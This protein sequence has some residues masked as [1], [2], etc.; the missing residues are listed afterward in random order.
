[1][2]AGD[3]YTMQFLFCDRRHVARFISG[4]TRGGKDSDVWV[5]AAA[6]EEREKEGN[7]KEREMSRKPKLQGWEVCW[8]QSKNV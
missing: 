4:G 3:R 1:M 2:S 5:G 8:Y 6:D 7:R